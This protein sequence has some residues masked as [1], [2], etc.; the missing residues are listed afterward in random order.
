[1]GKKILN[2]VDNYPQWG[3]NC[4]KENQA[5]LRAIHLLL[6]NIHLM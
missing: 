3:K 5:T 4:P 6:N 1:M 2:Y